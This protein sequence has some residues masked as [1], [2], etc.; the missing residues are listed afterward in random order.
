MPPSE[1][2]DE[3]LAFGVVK[4]RGGAA[5]I[6]RAAVIGGEPGLDLGQHHLGDEGQVELARLG[7]GQPAEIGQLA[8]G[9]GEIVERSGDP[10][11]VGQEEA[12]VEAA[13]PPRRRDGAE[14]EL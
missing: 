11:G 14:D 1:R 3:G 6:D 7:Q 5:S 9:A 13:W 10:G 12:G 8:A 4:E 2:V